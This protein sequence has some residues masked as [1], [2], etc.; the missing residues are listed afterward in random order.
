MLDCR[1]P[2]LA[3]ASQP[4]LPLTVDRRVKPI[5]ANVPSILTAEARRA[6]NPDKWETV[7]NFLIA[8]RV[9]RYGSAEVKTR[10]VVA[11]EGE[12]CIRPEG[13]QHS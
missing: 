4:S 5:V 13:G 11:L 12:P 8:E 9:Y 1:E 6:A 10:L 2:R 7:G 3:A